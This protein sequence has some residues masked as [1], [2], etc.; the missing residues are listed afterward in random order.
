MRESTKLVLTLKISLRS[1]EHDRGPHLLSLWS[2]WVCM[3]PSGLPTQRGAGAWHRGDGRPVCSFYC[4][5]APFLLIDNALDALTTRSDRLRSSTSTPRELSKNPLDDVVALML[6]SWLLQGAV[7]GSAVK[8]L[9]KDDTSTSTAQLG[10]QTS[11]H[12]CM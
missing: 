8:N 1:Q 11:P 6:V 3:H 4:F 12:T 5:C 2:D 10:P 9:Q 7:R